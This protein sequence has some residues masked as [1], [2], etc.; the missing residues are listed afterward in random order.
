[1]LRAPPHDAHRDVYSGAS[2]DPDAFCAGIGRL[3]DESLR[4]KLRLEKIQAGSILAQ[5]VTAIRAAVSLL[6]KCESAPMAGMGT[7]LKVNLDTECVDVSF[8]PAAQA[9]TFE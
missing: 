7:V 1:M 3:V 4:C 8:A 6:K 2:T 9:S 5:V